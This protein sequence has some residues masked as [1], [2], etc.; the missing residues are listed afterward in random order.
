[1][2]MVFKTETLLHLVSL[3]APKLHRS[4]QQI[5][6]ALDTSTESLAVEEVY[7]HMEPMNFSKDLLEVFD[8]CSRSQ[9]SVISMKGVFWSD[10]GSGDRIIS[11]LARLRYLDRFLG[12]FLQ[13]NARGQLPRQVSTF[14]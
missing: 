14:P 2:V 10:W 4:F 13:S 8:S 1:M 5:L 3:L 7:R 9:L 12:R 6:Q 11:V